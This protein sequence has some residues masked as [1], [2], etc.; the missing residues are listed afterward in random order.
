[1]R[2]FFSGGAETFSGLGRDRRPVEGGVPL[3]VGK[4]RHVAERVEQ[5]A[6]KAE[7]GK[8][9]PAEE[10]SGLEVLMVVDEVDDGLDS[11]A[12]GACADKPGREV[13]GA[14]GDAENGEC[15]KHKQHPFFWE[16]VDC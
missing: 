11:L 15:S 8:T 5:F 13:G 2:R 4:G 6:D 12:G 9:P 16:Q 10:M 1:M 3:P 14:D 7:H